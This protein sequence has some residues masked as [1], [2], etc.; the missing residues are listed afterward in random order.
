M[1]RRVETDEIK[2]SLSLGYVWPPSFPL[3]TPQATGL[4]YCYGTYVLSTRLP[5]HFEILFF[6]LIKKAEEGFRS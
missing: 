5:A 6:L 3:S 2:D 4:Y 1:V